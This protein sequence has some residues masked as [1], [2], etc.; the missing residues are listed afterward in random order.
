M[1]LKPKLGPPQTVRLSGGLGVNG[2]V[3][4]REAEAFFDLN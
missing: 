2:Y 3:P 1:L 4:E